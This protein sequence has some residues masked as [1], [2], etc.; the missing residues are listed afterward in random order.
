MPKWVIE[1][2]LIQA[3]LGGVD[4]LFVSEPFLTEE[5]AKCF[6]T[7]LT[8]KGYTVAVQ[9]DDEERLHTI[10]GAELVEWLNS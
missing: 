4:P 2:S 6:A 8:N 5:G 1:G 3:S 10:A 9:T 7:L